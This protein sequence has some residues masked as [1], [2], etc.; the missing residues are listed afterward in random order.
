MKIKLSADKSTLASKDPVTIRYTLTNTSKVE[1]PTAELYWIVDREDGKPVA[2]APEGA[3]RKEA[4]RAARSMN[5]VVSLGAGDSK[6]VEETLSK[7]YVMD[8][9]G[10]YIVS[11]EMGF[12]DEIKTHFVKSNP[13]RITITQ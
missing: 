1:I 2:D 13:L 5:V 9:P 4:R 12:N 10:V 6:T 7:L 8:E 3:R 11:A